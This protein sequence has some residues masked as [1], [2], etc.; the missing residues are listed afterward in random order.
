MAIDSFLPITGT[1]VSSWTVKYINSYTFHP[2]AYTY[3][4]LFG[5]L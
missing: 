2:K 1:L 5:F 4:A 3:M